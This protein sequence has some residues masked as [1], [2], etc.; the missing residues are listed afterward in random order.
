MERKRILSLIAL[1]LTLLIAEIGY[2]G[3]A[4]ASESPSLSSIEERTS[5]AK[6][7]AQTVLSIVQHPKGSYSQRKD[8][9]RNAFS[10]IVDIDWMGKFALGRAWLTASDEQ[11]KRYM[12]VYR[13]YLT[14]SYVG[15]FA[16]KPEKRIRDITINSVTE[17]AQA[18]DFNVRTHMML[19]DSQKLQVNYMVSEQGGHYKI[20]DIAIENISLVGT[21]RSEFQALASLRGVEG[22]ISELKSRL[23]TQSGPITLSMK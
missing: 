11:K 8:T 19:A 1:T 22:V 9:L 2:V 4:M 7:F 16:E 5:Y 15:N 18:E 20:R 3:M 12:D 23:G 6:E 21:H 17:A 13:Q 10:S 14:E